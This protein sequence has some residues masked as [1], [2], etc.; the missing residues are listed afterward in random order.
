MQRRIEHLTRDFPRYAVPR[1]AWLT[2]EPWTA[3]LRHRGIPARLVTGLTLTKGPEQRAHPLADPGADRVQGGHRM[4]PEAGRV[5][6]ARI[7]G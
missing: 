1:A 7:E 6:V 3:L 4:A 2:L 5:V